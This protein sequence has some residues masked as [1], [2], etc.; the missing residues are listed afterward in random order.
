MRFQ[1]SA[2]RRC[3]EL[4]PQLRVGGTAVYLIRRCCSAISG[5]SPRYAMLRCSFP[6][7]DVGLYG[8]ICGVPRSAVQDEADL[9]ASVLADAASHLQQAPH[10]D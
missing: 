4:V 9:G 7:A 2:W 1:V 5:P 10:R 8:S 6:E 3:G